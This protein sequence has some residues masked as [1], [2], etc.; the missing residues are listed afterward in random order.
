MSYEFIV[1]GNEMGLQHLSELSLQ[2]SGCC[3]FR[4]DWGSGFTM[5]QTGAKRGKLGD[6][7][8][9]YKGEE[10]RRVWHTWGLSKSAPFLTN[11]TRFPA[12]S[13]LRFVLLPGN[14]NARVLPTKLN[15]G[16]PNISVDPWYG[17]M[18]EPGSEDF[19]I[20][21]ILPYRPALECS[22]VASWYHQDTYLGPRL[23]ETNNDLYPNFTKTVL[24]SG[25]HIPEGIRQ[26][27]SQHPYTSY[28]QTIFDAMPGGALECSSRW[29][30]V[31]ILNEHHLDSSNCSAYRD[32]QRLVRAVYVYGRNL[33]RQ[34]ALAYVDPEWSR[35]NRPNTIERVEA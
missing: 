7:R 25:T 3:T 11:N 5:A 31:S 12:N 8:T 21:A 30:K 15:R 27:L 23:T 16:S 33:F 26:I 35:K 18:V 14:Q 2:V 13:T 6:V 1:R 19:K 20:E 4:F 17:T 22:E 32:V 29:V 10:P 28:V 24:P 34:A 9:I